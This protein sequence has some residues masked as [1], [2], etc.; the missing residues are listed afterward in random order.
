MKQ[1]RISIP[2]TVNISVAA[3]SEEQAKRLA[4]AATYT[5]TS[6]LTSL[7]YDSSN[8]LLDVAVWVNDEV[9]ENPDKCEIA[10]TTEATDPEKLLQQLEEFAADNANDEEFYTASKFKPTPN[11]QPTNTQYRKTP[12]IHIQ[13]AKAIL[14]QIGENVAIVEE[15]YENIFIETESGKVYSVSIVECEE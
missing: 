8:N 10:D 12:Q 14:S 15:T 4:A 11:Q 7:T 3:E 13:I 1:Y 2:A 9:S 5:P 6:G